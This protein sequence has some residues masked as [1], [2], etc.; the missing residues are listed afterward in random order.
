M[1]K[2]FE[3]SDGA[4]WPSSRASHRG[5]LSRT[6]LGTWDSHENPLTKF[7]IQEAWLLW[8]LLTRQARD[9]EARSSFCCCG[10]RVSGTLHE[11]S[12]TC[13]GVAE[14]ASTPRLR[15]NTL[16]GSDIS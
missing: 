15:Q 11:L 1:C 3:C 4:G 6:L 9:A 14:Q 16:Q 13:P 5:R 12:R 7:S 10:T 2:P 8:R